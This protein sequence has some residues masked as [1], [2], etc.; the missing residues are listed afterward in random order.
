MTANCSRLW[1]SQ[2]TF[3]PTT[4][5]IAPVR[6][7]VGNTAASAGRST[8]GRAPR[9]IL[10]VAIASPVLPAVTKPAARPSRTSRIPT[11]IED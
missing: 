4:S 8:P 11:C 2:S 10:A 5:S 9:I 1:G 6:M 7:A 3:A